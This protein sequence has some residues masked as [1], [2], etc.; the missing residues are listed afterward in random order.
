MDFSN[1][2]SIKNIPYGIA[3]SSS[4]PEKA[5][6]TRLHD[7]VFFLGDLPIQTSEDIKQAF[8]QVRSSR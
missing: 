8:A 5:V 1:H 6:A 3:T 2:F 7:R 4:H